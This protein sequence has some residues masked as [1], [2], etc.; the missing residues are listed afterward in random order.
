MRFL[1]AI[2][3]LLFFG[4]SW[5]A[6]PAKPAPASVTGEV[7]EVQDVDSYTYLRLKTK[8]GETWAAVS[9][10]PVQ[11]GAQV[12]IEN[13]AVM[14]NF[15]S[16][17]LKRKFDRIVFG[18]LAGTGPGSAGKGGDL[19][20]MH[21][22]VAKPTDAGDVKVAKATG[23]NARTVAEIVA[24]SA[25]LKDKPVVVRGK[26]VKFTP[27]VMGKNW[28]HLRDGTGSAADNTNDVLVTT[29]DEAKIG[30][31]VLVTGIVH[32][33]K[34]LGSGYSYKVLIEEAKLKK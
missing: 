25:E 23:P 9:R 34:D 7:L 2:V 24:K 27:A 20:A 12:T 22:G 32:T 29:K 16:K 8:E 28:V 15:E 31:V 1:S 33:D 17:T 13:P 6:D 5:A 14:S 11:K 3:V 4:A 19:T 10:A 21:A 26:V 30:D 18:T